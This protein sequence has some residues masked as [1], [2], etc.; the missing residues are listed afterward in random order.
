VTSLTLVWIDTRL[1][2]QFLSFMVQFTMLYHVDNSDS[3]KV[4]YF[5]INSNMGVCSPL[6]YKG[7]D[8]QT[9]NL[10]FVISVV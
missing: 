6:V 5:W 7:T 2:E 4:S 9:K 10:T 3:K 8:P 1:F